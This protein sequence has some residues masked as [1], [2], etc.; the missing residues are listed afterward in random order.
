MDSL[1]QKG[2]MQYPFDPFLKEYAV[3]LNVF[4]FCNNLKLLVSSINPK[5]YGMVFS[6]HVQTE[7]YD[8][9]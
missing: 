8:R 6:T 2:L 5:W 9:H 3:D 4:M 7:R 1:G